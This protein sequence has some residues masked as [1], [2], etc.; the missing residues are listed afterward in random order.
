[1]IVSFTPG[2]ISL[3]A[4]GLSP[5]GYKWGA[6]NKDATSDQ[7][8]GFSTNMGE[9]CQLLLSDKI[10]GYFLV[11]EDDVWNYSF[12]GSSFGSAKNLGRDEAPFSY[13]RLINSRTEEILL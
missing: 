12:L 5:A 4:W 8:Q 13:L 3:S 9:K 7:P 6:E 1:M 10:R 2:S 11:P